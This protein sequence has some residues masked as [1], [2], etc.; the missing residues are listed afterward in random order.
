MKKKIKVMKANKKAKVTKEPK[1][2]K[3]ASKQKE[4]KV[5]KKN[6]DGKSGIMVD[7]DEPKEMIILSDTD[8]PIK[9]V[10]HLSD[11]HIRKSERHQEYRKV[12]EELYLKI[13]Q[14]TTTDLDSII[15][16][17]GD[18]CHSKSSLTSSQVELLQE[19]IFKLS[20]LRNVLLIPGNHDLPLQT[21]SENGKMADSLGSIVKYMKT[22]YKVHYLS[23]D[24][25]YLC[26]NCVFTHT[27]MF[28]NKVT[29]FEKIDGKINI[30]L[31]HGTIHGTTINGYDISNSS[32]FNATAFKGYDLCMFGD[33]HKLSYINSARTMA[34]P[35]SLIQQNISEDLLDHGYI[36]WNVI[37]KTSEFVR[38][39]NEHGMVKLEIDN[40]KVTKYNDN[41]IPKYPTF[42]IYYKNI[43]SN[44]LSDYVIKLKDKFPNTKC[45]TYNVKSDEDTQ[46]TF[47]NN[48]KQKKSISEITDNKIAQ[49]M[50]M[51]Y[52]LKKDTY[53][54]YSV[55]EKK[56]FKLFL[57]N[58]IKELDYNYGSST[59]HI[60]LESLS[61][62]NFFLYGENNK[63]VF[64]KFNNIVGLCGPSY[65]GKSSILDCL[66]F[67]IFGKC[68][69]GSKYN[70]IN[71]NTDKVTTVIKLKINDSNY[72]ITRIRTKK[73][74]SSI[75]CDS[76]EKL[77]LLCNGKNINCDTLDLTN[78][79]INDLMGG[80]EDYINV[81]IILQKDKNSFIDMTEQK[82]KDTI[83]R[84]FK[85]DLFDNI[86][87]TANNKALMMKRELYEPAKGKKKK[88]LIDYSSKLKE[89]K[90]DIKSNNTQKDIIVN[91]MNELQENI[92]YKEKSVME[93]EIKI[94]QYE[95]SEID[96][97]ELEDNMKKNIKQ[98]KILDKK[99]TEL[100]NIQKKYNKNVTELELLVTDI[101][102]YGD[103]D[104]KHSV[105]EIKKQK[106]IN[107]LNSEY[108]KLFML[109]KGEITIN[110]D[111]DDIYENISNLE[112][113]KNTL[114]DQ[115]D[116]LEKELTSIQIIK[117]K[118]SKTIIK[119]YE[120]FVLAKNKKEEMVNKIKKNKEEYNIYIDKLKNIKDHTFDPGCQYCLSYPT[121]RDKQSFEKIKTELEHE[122]TDYL[123]ELK[124]I[125]K[126]IKDTSKY[127]TKYDDMQNLKETNDKNTFFIKEHENN[128]SLLGKDLQ[129]VNN[130]YEQAHM[131]I[132]THKV[133]EQIVEENRKINNKCKKIKKLIEESE[134]RIDLE[135]EKYVKIVN[136]KD[137]GTDKKDMLEKELNQLK[138]EIDDITTSINKIDSMEKKHKNNLNE[139]KKIKEL[140]TKQSKVLD[141]YK[142]DNEK[143]QNKLN[144]LDKTLINL[145]VQKNIEIKNIERV[146][147]IQSEYDMLELIASVFSDGMMITNIMQST[148]F[149]V[150]EM[151][152]NETLENMCD[153]KIKLKCVSK[154][155]MLEK[156]RQDGK[157]INIETLSGC[158][159]VVLNIAFRFALTK[160]NNFIKTEC[161]FID[162]I[163]RYLDAS[164]IQSVVTI[165]DYIRENYKWG[166]LISHDE[167]I[168]Q[169]YD[170]SIY[171]QKNEDMSSK[172]TFDPVEKIIKKVEKIEVLKS[173]LKKKK[174][175]KASKN[176]RSVMK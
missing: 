97:N 106:E 40:K 58:I 76:S 103:M 14:D 95:K 7:I 157:V 134:K 41:D 158:E 81:S 21:L 74:R 23:E 154:G 61:F 132:E 155:I 75:D 100:K 104:K 91:D 138:N 152:V 118:N 140:F 66:L 42:Y 6:K 83:S 68:S 136:E 162:E 161:I 63:I 52:I 85:L 130:Q 71:I 170:S 69:R 12:F 124:E 11:I 53:K 101:K 64:N 8:T 55:P 139:Y 126:D 3:K 148:I 93:C 79:Y 135:Y 165:F 159:N 88:E 35:S 39:K 24:R 128:I 163:F 62:S 122:L 9:Y 171:V 116:C 54:K 164:K 43:S 70:A 77:E 36:K 174:T 59:K 92:S 146:N 133:N 84:L 113:K 2:I 111:I 172:I 22:D 144:K 20:Q 34:Y 112:K 47:G 19:F 67:S 28:T 151:Q 25:S 108:E 82:R 115:I 89:I 46:I 26:E 120:K 175:V 166:L 13:S 5:K 160:Y 50:I 51:S 96:M 169:L 147:S 131:Y 102:S 44:D 10:Y 15:V 94:E 98:K 143:Q 49:K 31:Y 142:L 99:K 123:S 60:T 176:I 141:T 72:Q 73:N 87:K 173:K 145:R 17:T 30:A 45:F 56:E 48:K 127:E 156:I 37:D 90:K 110:C 105:F 65:S 150:I 125:N 18:V 129:L 29:R 153:Y 33:I 4:V 107:K 167:R 117:I 168:V 27:T 119:N 38:V 149:P 16:I 114:T 137:L 57:N 32:N 80:Y 1:I 78:K 86:G 109:K 121:T